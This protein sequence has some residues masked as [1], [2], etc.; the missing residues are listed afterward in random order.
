MKTCRVVR[1]QAQ[2]YPG[3]H[4]IR[5]LYLQTLPPSVSASLSARPV[6]VQRGYEQLQAYIRVQ[7]ER[8]PLQNSCKTP[9]RAMIGPARLRGSFLNQSRCWRIQSSPEPGLGP[10]AHLWWRLSHR[11]SRV[12]MQWWASPK[13]LDD[14]KPPWLVSLGDYQEASPNNGRRLH[15]G[16]SQAD[17]K[18]TMWAQVVYLGRDP[19]KLG[20]RVGT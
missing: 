15:W 9:R 11:P 6:H 1:L 5:N 17:P 12:I 8:E 3:D 16:A 20:G 2:L 10:S 4:V 13:E 7:R 18:M 14:G 19:R